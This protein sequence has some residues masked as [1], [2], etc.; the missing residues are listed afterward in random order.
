MHHLSPIRQKKEESGVQTNRVIIGTCLGRRQV[1]K[2][3]S[4][5]VKEGKVTEK[6]YALLNPIP[7]AFGCSEIKREKGL[8]HI[9][10]GLLVKPGKKVVAEWGLPRKD[11]KKKT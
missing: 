4:Q 5:K 2:I 1:K 7:K 10:G 8:G 6:A 3:T 9:R 11:S